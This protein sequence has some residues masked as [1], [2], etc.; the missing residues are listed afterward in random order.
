MYRL[1][2]CKPGPW[3]FEGILAFVL[4]ILDPGNGTW[5][6]QVA[7]L[8][9]W[10]SNMAFAFSTLFFLRCARQNVVMDGLHARRLWQ[11]FLQNLV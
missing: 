9:V 2:S 11:A 4:G 6:G 3:L 1:S 7:R 5:L 8:Y 10:L